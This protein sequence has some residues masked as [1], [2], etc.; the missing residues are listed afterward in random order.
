[1]QRM[2][3]GLWGSARL[4]LSCRQGERLRLISAK[5]VRQG[6]LRLLFQ[7]LWKSLETLVKVLGKSRMSQRRIKGTSTA[8]APPSLPKRT[9]GGEASGE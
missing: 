2:Q 8:A 9:E 4:L 6:V 7:N 3:R 1:M 5:H